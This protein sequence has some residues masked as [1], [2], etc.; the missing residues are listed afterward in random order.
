MSEQLNPSPGSTIKVP[1]YKGDL[2]RGLK[3]L[4]PQQR[5][6]LDLQLVEYARL[7]ELELHSDLRDRFA[8]GDTSLPAGTLLHGTGFSPELIESLAVHGVVSGELFGIPEDAETH[9]CADFFRVEDATTLADYSKWIA[10]SEPSTTR[11]RTRRMEGQYLPSDKSRGENMGLVVDPTIPEVQGLLEAD[12]YR[13]GTDELFEG[14]VTHLPVDK[15]TPKAERLSAILGGVPRGAIAGIVVSDRLAGNSEHM[16]DLVKA[17][18]RGMPLLSVRGEL[19]NQA[20]T[21]M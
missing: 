4:G 12:A 13:A 19:L 10:E 17:F 11:V 2:E 18:G 15:S 14:I 3:E 7:S 1:T 21:G 16:A 5:E 8:S 9:Y 20:I 6:V